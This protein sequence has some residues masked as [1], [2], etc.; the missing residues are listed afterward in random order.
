MNDNI[1]DLISFK[2]YEDYENEWKNNYINYPEKSGLLY[3]EEKKK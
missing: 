1:K 2:L 3:I